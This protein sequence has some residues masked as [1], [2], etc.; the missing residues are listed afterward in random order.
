MLQL[1]NELDGFSKCG[2][3]KLIM[4]TNRI[5]S[6]D[7]ALLR[8]GRI[9]R[10]IEFPLP[11]EKTKRRFFD[12]QTAKMTLSDDIDIEEYITSKVSQML[13]KQSFWLHMTSRCQTKFQ[14]KLV[15]FHLSA[16]NLRYL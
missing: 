9:D 15:N 3:V 1:L 10:K 12:I 5:D 4:A 7:S 6:M 16:F 11:N 2:D 8:P 14:H 13:S